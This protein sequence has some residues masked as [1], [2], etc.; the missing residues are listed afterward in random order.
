[1]TIYSEAQRIPGFITYD[2]SPT[3]GRLTETSRDPETTPRDIVRE[4]EVDIVMRLPIARAIRDWLEAKI[5][6]LEKAVG[7]DDKS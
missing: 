1:M 5:R 2:V 7:E 3:T 6:D 4:L